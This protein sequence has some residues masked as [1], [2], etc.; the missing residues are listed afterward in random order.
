LK[1]A[2]GKDVEEDLIF[3]VKTISPVDTN[4]LPC[5]PRRSATEW[6]VP[7]RSV[8]A[9]AARFGNAETTARQT[10][11][12]VHTP[13]SRVRHGSLIEKTVIA[14]YTMNTLPVPMGPKL[15][16]SDASL[17]TTR[18]PVQVRIRAVVP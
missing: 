10:P 15:A 9:L 4:R 16:R 18:S 13:D 7:R 14:P 8:K 2:N 6:S 12:P 3:A 5:T 17:P 11:S 1:T